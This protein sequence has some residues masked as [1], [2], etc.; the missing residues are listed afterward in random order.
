MAMDRPVR[1]AVARRDGSHR[2]RQR[3]RAGERGGCRPRRAGVRSRRDG[4]LRAARR[5]N[6]R[7][8]R[9]QPPLVP[10]ARP[11]AARPAV[12]RY[13]ASRRGRAHH[14]GRAAA[15]RRRCG[16]ARRSTRATRRREIEITRPSPPASTWA[17]SAR[18]SRAASSVLAAGRR[19]R[20]Q[21]VGAARV[22]R[23]R[24]RS[25]RPPP[26]RAH[27]RHRQRSGR[28][29]EPEGS[30]TRSTTP[31]RRCCA[32][33]RARRRRAGGASARW[34]TTRIPSALRSAAPGADVML[35]SGGSSVGS[36]DHAPRLLAE[37]GRARDSRRRDA[38]VE[39]RGLR[40][41]RRHAGVPAARQPGVVPVRLRLLRR[42]RDP[43]A[44]RPAA[45]LAASHDAA[46]RSP[47]RSFRRSDAS[48]TAASGCVDGEVEPLALSGASILSSTTRADGFVDR[49]RRKRRLCAR[50]RSHGLPL[51][52]D[53]TPWRTSLTGQ[54]AAGRRRPTDAVPRR[55]HPRRGDRALPA[56]PRLAAAGHGRPSA[57][58]GAE[59]RAARRR[60]RPTSTCPASIARTSMA[61]RC[62]PR[63]TFGARRRRRA[64]WRSTP[65]CSRRAWCLRERS[66]PGRATPI[67]TG[68]MLPRG[69]DAV[70]MVEHTEVVVDPDG[71]GGRD[72][73]RAVTAGENVS[74]AGTDIARGETVLRA[75]QVLTSR[76]IGVLAAIGIA[77][78]RRVSPAARG[79]P[80]DRQ[81]DRARPACRCGRARSTTPT[82]RSSAPP[83]KSWAASRCTSA[84]FATTKTLSPRRS[85]RALAARRGASVGRHVQRRGRPLVPRREPARRTRASS[86]TASRSSRASRSAWRSPMASPS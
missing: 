19:L 61:S 25:R 65:K 40:P 15:R 16:G 73:A 10:R 18:T 13:G 53:L 52:L 38:A 42:S 24:S 55:H 64:A 7:R 66:C 37:V 71:R 69:A 72:P 35:V 70:L 44:R 82:P 45:A 81:R 84:S 27:R 67:A 68:G 28:A 74:Y 6:L 26:A 60:V 3:P 83:W 46:C 85:T 1:Q 8:Q 21:D 56:T 39:P 14:D 78:I 9:L 22:A 76:E 43:A 12:R 58:R 23:H 30:C 57:G 79:H 63:D 33:C 2:P 34:V 54:G 77:Q 62:R 48:T 41:H 51:R 50:Q 49:A 86:R 31:T 20:P 36:E 29:G 47:A 5:R 75:G 11:G 17:A 32:A 59:P 80:L 4:R